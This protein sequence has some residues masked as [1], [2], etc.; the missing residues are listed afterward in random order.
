M[1]NACTLIK[2]NF[3]L[4]KVESRQQNKE[5]KFV[6][7]RGENIVG[8]GDNAAY[9]MEKKKERVLKEKQRSPSLSNDR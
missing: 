4:V 7:R 1:Q 8:K 2:I 5:H 3:K 9:Q 6:V